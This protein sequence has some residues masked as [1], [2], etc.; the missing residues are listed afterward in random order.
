VGSVYGEVFVWTVA[1]RPAAIASIFRWY[2]PFKDGTIEIVS[3]SPAAISARDGGN[4]VWDC[5]SPG[6]TWQAVDGPAPSAAKGAR[7]TQ[8]RAL[9]RRLSA[10]LKDKRGGEPI[11]RDL[12]L[13]GQPLHRYESAAQDVV[14]GAVFAF[15]EVTDPEVIALVEAFKDES[16]ARWRYALARMNNHA[17]EVS[18]DGKIV[19]SWP[20]IDR[21]WADRKSS[22]TLFSFDPAAVL[23]SNPAP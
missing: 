20:H 21:P 13:L 18:L 15:A 10:Q 2:H 4:L 12:R 17:L 6:L 11:V 1:D 23:D 16:S 14:D 22:Y 9:V 3:L 19:Q 5:R 8:M 7:L